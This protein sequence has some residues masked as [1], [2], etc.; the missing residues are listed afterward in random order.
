LPICISEFL[1][2]VSAVGVDRVPGVV[3]VSA[4]SGIPASAIVITVSDVPGVLAL[5]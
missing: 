4:I 3:I 5:A 2:L 1:P